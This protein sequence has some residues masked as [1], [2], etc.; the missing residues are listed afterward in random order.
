M[1]KHRVEAKVDQILEVFNYL[2]LR[3]GSME[4]ALTSTQT[5]VEE[6]DDKLS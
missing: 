2:K 3:V 6:I 5:H 4:K 1:K